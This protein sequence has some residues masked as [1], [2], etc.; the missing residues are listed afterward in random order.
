MILVTNAHGLLECA[1]AMIYDDNFTSYR[2]FKVL[3]RTIFLRCRT[4]EDAATNSNNIQLKDGLYCYLVLTGFDGTHLMKEMLT[5]CVL[6]EC[7]RHYERAVDEL[8]RGGPIEMIVTD[9][10]ASASATSSSSSSSSAAPP[11]PRSIVTFDGC[12]P[13]L[14]TMITRLNAKF[15]ERGYKGFKFAAASTMGEQ[16]NDVGHCH[17]AIKFCYRGDK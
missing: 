9:H 2:S 17:K 10:N 15:M 3:L 6:P 1:I 4:I 14:H 12:W 8:L 5:D 16:P 7:D 11:R 13:Q